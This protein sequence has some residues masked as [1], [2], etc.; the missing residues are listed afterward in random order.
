VAS[1]VGGFAASAGPIVQKVIVDDVI[2]AGSRPLAT[3]LGL[4]LLVGLIALVT[5]VLRR[6]WGSVFS[7]SVQ[8]DLRVATFR[9]ALAL[10]A[11]SREEYRPGDMFSRATADVSLLNVVLGRFHN[12]IGNIVQ[13]IAAIVAMAILSPRL[14]G[15]VAICIPAFAV[16][17]RLMRSRLFP[18]TWHSQRSLAVVT[19]KVAETVGSIRVVKA[20]GQS[21][22]E[23]EK[24][25]QTSRDLF[26]SRLR[27]LRLGSF[28]GATLEALPGI[29]QVLVVVV[30]GLLAIDGQ[31]SPGTFVAFASFVG[32]LLGPVRSLSR[33]FSNSQQARAGAERIYSFLDV[34]PTV[35]DG[36]RG[37]PVPGAGSVQIEDVHFGYG[38]ERQVFS[39][40]TLDIEP[41]ERV[42]IVGLSG[43]GKSTLARL[44][45]R[46]YDVDRG[47]IRVDG[48][49]V[50]DHGL[51]DLRE[52]VGGV[53]EEPFLFSVSI[54]ENI[55]FGVPS[56]SDEQIE[57][58]AR[59]AGAT[60]FIDRLPDG[61]D[62]I[63]GERGTTLSGGQRQRLILARAVLNNRKVLILDDATSAIDGRTE[64]AIHD[65]LARVM[66]GRTTI[67]FAQRRSTL[68]L[69]D[70]IVVLDDGRVAA[71]GVLQ[72]LLEQ[73]DVFQAIW[74]AD[75]GPNGS[76]PPA[77]A[78]GPSTMHSGRLSDSRAG[79]IQG[80]LPGIRHA[81]ADSRRAAIPMETPGLME[82]IERLPALDGEPD[83]SVARDSSP[84]AFGLRSLIRPFRRPLGVGLI[85]VSVSA[86]LALVSPLLVREAIDS[87]I[88]AR[89]R[90]VVWVVG[91]LMLLTVIASWHVMRVTSVHTGRTAE[92]MLFV[93]RVRTFRQLL[94]LPIGYFDRQRT[95]RVI[96]RL[97]ADVEALGTLL[98]DGLIA[99]AVGSVT[100]LGAL[101]LLLA[102]NWRLGLGV[103]SMLVPIVLL[104]FVFRRRARVAHLEARETLSSVYAELAE[105]IEAAT[106]IQLDR[107]E[108]SMV[109]RF[110]A[111][112]REY[113]QARLRTI[114]LASGY[115][116]AM[117]YLADIAS[118]VVLGIGAV[119]IE[120]DQLTIGLLLAFLL[121]VN[122]FFSPMQS[123]SEQID[124]W[125]AARVS[126]LK[127]G[128]LMAEEPE[129]T[130]GDGNLGFVSPDEMSLNGISFSY[131][132]TPTD[133]IH[134]L[135]LDLRPGERL[136]IVGATGA[137]KSTL[138]KLL[139][140]FY[141]PTSGSVRVRGTSLADLDLVRHRRRIG[142]VQQEPAV[143]SA[144]VRENIAYGKPDATDAEVEDAARL[145]G[146]HDA[147]SW[148]P[149]GYDTVLS[150]STMSA[151]ER[152]LIC[153]ARAMLI[154]PDLLILDEA[155]ANLDMA[156]E[157]RVQEAMEEISRTM[158][159]VVIAHR[160]QTVMS[161]DRV[162][163][164][165]DGRVVEDGSHEGLLAEAGVYASMWSAFAG[166]DRD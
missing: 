162:V 95:G 73:S 85:L 164:L 29:G 105:G 39:G 7:H 118:V 15:I 30:G 123:L 144:T 70:R 107:A 129:Q 17:S 71:D 62:T 150:Q 84:D 100:A 35:S 23:A 155:T 37:T 140:G 119:M 28:Y 77:H 64:R 102:L 54:R 43:S 115:F 34:E 26:R 50:R 117:R 158:T 130:R 57:A 22:T 16:T 49:D 55:A 24:Y 110:A 9:K 165:E 143:F 27:V 32:Q 11:M 58:A 99:T 44:L 133:V 103:A 79:R 109:E 63:V 14:A 81:G 53:I 141:Q 157:A 80:H 152:Q 18:A 161:A 122:Y 10:D 93:L 41:G 111:T 90:D 12:Q 48:Q 52:R 69:V 147:V 65:G 89:S 156:S 153:L 131:P 33:F 96:A 121:Y 45:V 128:G 132:T 91:G 146:I 104:T 5:T 75:P 134:D 136:A 59:V 148:L 166:A 94:S 114:R 8:H 159:T 67:L 113:M 145:V 142:Y 92:R 112:S 137:G 72:E 139:M 83:Q 56:T 68:R 98:Q 21:A 1:T 47:S 51:A 3:W 87:G 82:A 74:G 31:V 88:L 61:Y 154:D 138:A 126:L 124:L 106:S 36:A 20:F 78:P 38:P 25:A 76:G 6:Y 40:L 2:L 151:G 101:I 125:A 13:V 149:D 116:P 135:T 86:G 60:E 127:L 19:T 42:A 66:T 4:L 120:N 46:M 97:T 108:G 163:V 160:L